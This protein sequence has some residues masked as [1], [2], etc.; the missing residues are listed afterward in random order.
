MGLVRDQLTMA[1]FGVGVLASAF[2][3]AFRIPNLFRRLLGEGALTAAFIPTFQSTLT[4]QGKAAA[5]RLVNEVCSWLLLATGGLVLIASAIAFGISCLPGQEARVLLAAELSLWLFPY[6]ILVC[7]AAVLTATLN[8]LQRFVEGALSPVV[9]NL[10]MIACLGGAGLAFSDKPLVRMYW[11]CAGVLFGGFCQ[12]LVP[13]A[14]LWRQGWRPRP[15]FQLSPGVREIGLLMIPGIWGAASYQINQLVV[16][17]LALSIDDAAASLLFYS[18]RLMELPI[19]VFTIAIATVV[20]PLLS[21]HAA[22]GDHG[23]MAADYLRGIRLILLVTLP[24]SV[25]L[26]L[27]NE[28]IVR[29]LFERG[30][31]TAQDTAAMGPLLALAVAGLPF[32]SVVSLCS[33]AFYAIKDTATPVRLATVGFGINLLLAFTLRPWLGVVGLVFASTVAV[34][35][36]CLLLQSRLAARLPGLAFTSLRADL[37]RMLVA[38]AGMALLVWGGWI[39]FCQGRGLAG[40]LLALLGLIPLAIVVY[41]LL[42]YG[43][44]FRELPWSSRKPSDAS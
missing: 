23:A 34:I 25:G 37:C 11:L 10:A 33:R 27:L 13:A 20:Y 1:V 40:D 43:L 12:L 7:L 42:L 31:F 4:Q 30:H 28:P 32:L 8:V 2:A 9:L 18:T 41:A 19:G 17:G 24:A 26:A 22:E 39:H 35:V 21:K 29:V 38:S 14:S 16:Q 6:L 44:G 5:F 36:Q 3:T 15:E